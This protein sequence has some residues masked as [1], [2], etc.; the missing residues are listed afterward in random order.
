MQRKEGEKDVLK[1]GWP[2]VQCDRRGAGKGVKDGMGALGPWPLFIMP[3]EPTKRCLRPHLFR[4]EV[5]RRDGL[6]KGWL[7]RG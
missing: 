4:K 2:T 7:E 3:A 1:G 6:D 5:A